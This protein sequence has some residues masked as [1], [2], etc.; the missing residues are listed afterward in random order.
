MT[1]PKLATPVMKNCTTQVRRGSKVE[2]CGNRIQSGRCSKKGQHLH[3]FVTGYCNSGWHEG[4]KIDKPT[5]KFWVTCPCECHARISLMAELT[6]TDRAMVDN[7]T[8]VPDR[9]AFVRVSLAESVQASLLSKPNVTLKESPAPGI[10]PIV[11][12]KKFDPT[13]TGRAAK[14]ELESWVRQITDIWAVEGGT[15]CTPTY[16]SEAIGKSRGINPPS[17]GAVHAVFMRWEQIG[18]AVI[19]RKPTRFSGYTPEGIQSGLEV[20]KARA[21]R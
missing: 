9:E 4:F 16:V 19:E 8:Y 6:N 12:E 3:P 7:S 1:Q 13:A 21:K 15:N 18:F 2:D 14:G 17:S 10:V 20:M 5:C 11:L